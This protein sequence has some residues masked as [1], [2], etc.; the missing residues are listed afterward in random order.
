MSTGLVV[1]NTELAGQ[2]VGGLDHKELKPVIAATAQ[3]LVSAEIEVTTPGGPLRTNAGEVGLIVDQSATI[4][5]AIELGS[6]SSW[7]QRPLQWMQSLITKRI[8][9]VIVSLDNTKLA[10]VIAERDPTKRLEPVEPTISADNDGVIRAIKGVNGHGLDAATVHQ[11]IAQAA[12]TGES[13]LRSTVTDVVLPPRFNLTDAEQLA[14]TAETLMETAVSVQA[15]ETTATVAPSMLKRWA[16]STPTEQ[17]LMLDLDDTKVMEDLAKLLDEA[18]TAPTDASFKVVDGVPVIVP[19]ANGT[20]CCSPAAAERILQALIS[21]DRSKQVV[22]LP[23]QT[24]EPKRSV[25]DARAMGVVEQVAT[26]TT[27]HPAKQSRVTNIHRIADLVQGTIIEPGKRLSL[28]D[29]V[30][31]RTID[32]GF[33]PAGVIY[34]GAFTE[35]VGG[36]VSQFATTLFNAA[37]F[38]GLDIPEYQSHSI[39]LDR[40]PRGRE[41]TLSYPKP[42]LVIENT[43]PHAVLIWSTYDATS[44]TVSLYS[45]RTVIGEQTGQT[46]GPS[47]ACTRVTTERTRTWLE[48]NRTKIDRFRATYRPEEGVAC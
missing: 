3:Q 27:R 9:P 25:A 48:D 45:T 5:H 4:A 8:A 30:G 33:V 41:A 2:P 15:G 22:K 18:G 10:T 32:A 23:L 46:E 43:T 12:K 39:W 26:F 35:D 47:G 20:E 6:Q 34:E 14:R 28:N 13:P 11:A 37:F 40:Y 1:R 17:N 29:L 38:A 36:G 44:I 24:A 21:P 31:K 19:G 42:D 7:W 16:S